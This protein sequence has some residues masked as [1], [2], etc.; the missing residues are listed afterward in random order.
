M[1]TQRARSQRASMIMGVGQGGAHDAVLAVEHAL[2]SGFNGQDTPALPS[3]RVVFA[4]GLT[5]RIGD[6]PIG[7]KA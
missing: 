3:E 6:Y 4:C 7:M 2:C 5:P 1:R